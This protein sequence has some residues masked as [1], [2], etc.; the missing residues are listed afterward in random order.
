M[1][2]RK[3]RKQCTLGQDPPTAKNFKSK[4]EQ[5]C[6]GAVAGD[7]RFL[8]FDSHGT[9]YRDEDGSGEQDGNDEG[10]TLAGNDDGTSKKVVYDD[11]VA[12]A[13]RAL[14][15]ILFIY[16]IYSYESFLQYLFRKP[17]VYGL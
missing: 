17:M 16:L 9:I 1:S 7:V 15:Y 12:K 4:V 14:I 2:T 13:T 3:K 5:L 10:W 11:W 8:Y 6:G